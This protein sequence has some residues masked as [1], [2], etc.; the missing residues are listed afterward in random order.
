MRKKILFT[1]NDILEGKRY[2][3]KS[4]KGCTDSR[5]L[6]ENKTNDINENKLIILPLMNLTIFI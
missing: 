4:E 6:N 2:Y 5:Y 1:N 3:L